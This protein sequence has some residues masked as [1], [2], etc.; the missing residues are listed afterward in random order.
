M[1]HRAVALF[2]AAAVTLAPPAGAQDAR[3]GMTPADQFDLQNLGEIR[4]SPDGGTVVYTASTADP[5]SNRVTTRVMKIAATGGAATE[6]AA[7]PAGAS[8]LRWSTDSTRI[9]FFASRDGSSAVWTYHMTSGTLTRLA[10]YDRTNRFIAKAGSFLTWS[11]DGAQIAFAGTL[12]PTP[13][14]GDPLVITRLQYKTR[15]AYSDDRWTQIFLVDAKGG[16]PRQLTHASTDHHSIDWTAGSEIVFLKNPEP[17]PDV[18]HNYDLYAIEAT[19]GRERRLTTTPGVE[20]DPRIS[21]DGK[22][23]AYTATTRPVTTIDSVAEDAHLWVMSHHGGDAREVNHA[24]DRRTS[25]PE[26]A[27]DSRAVLYLAADH[28]KTV[29]YRVPAL[30]GVSTALVDRKAQAG[31]YSVAKDEIGRAHV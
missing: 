8:N 25:S 5:E 4:I 6:L 2:C 12:E 3:R 9:A 15:T 27:P 30:G 11:P 18:A 28:G 1:L 16:P 31:P 21:P 19:T 20:M 22:L 13:A 23:I 26:W 29:L 10:D 24:L 17:D 14:P 7:I